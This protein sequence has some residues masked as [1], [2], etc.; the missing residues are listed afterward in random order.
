M[1]GL[2]NFREAM[3]KLSTK[4]DERRGEM[5][6]ENARRRWEGSLPQMMRL[7]RRIVFW[8]RSVS[9]P[10]LHLRLKWRPLVRLRCCRGSMGQVVARTPDW[11]RLTKG[12][13]DAGAAALGSG[14]GG[15]DACGGASIVERGGMMMTPGRLVRSLSLQGDGTAAL[16]EYDSAYYVNAVLAKE[17]CGRWRWC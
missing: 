10:S 16:M 9:P 1:S 2:A 12:E 14:G 6:L 5:M 15:Q 3:T 11:A 13:R 7:T 4:G 17:S 8:N